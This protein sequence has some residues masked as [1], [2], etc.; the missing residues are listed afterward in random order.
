MNNKYIIKNKLDVASLE[1]AEKDIQVINDIIIN[2]TA[3]VVFEIKK[4]WLQIPRKRKTQQKTFESI[5]DAEYW[6]F[7]F[8]NNSE[9]NIRLK[10]VVPNLFSKYRENL[11]KIKDNG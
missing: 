9:M 4:P 6:L 10:K 7:N 8:R 5:E 3:K 11:R 2:Y 1:T